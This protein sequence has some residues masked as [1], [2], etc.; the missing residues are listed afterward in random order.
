MCV[1]VGER[2]GE[3]EPGR[4]GVRRTQEDGGDKSVRRGGEWRTHSLFRPAKNVSDA[5]MDGSG[6]GRNERATEGV[7]E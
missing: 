5:E 3:T 4:G 2:E 1:R 6:E 7:R